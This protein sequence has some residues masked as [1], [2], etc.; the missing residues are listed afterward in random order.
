MLPVL[1]E[2]CEDGDC[3][4]WK[5]M[6]CSHCQELCLRAYLTPDWLQDSRARVD[7]QSEVCITY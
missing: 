7:N 5:L 4:G 6:R 3:L 2:K 1:D